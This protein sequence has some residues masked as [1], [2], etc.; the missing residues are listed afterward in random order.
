[1][2][3]ILSWKANS[4]SA[5]QDVPSILWNLEVHYYIHRSQPLVP[6]PSHMI[7]VHNLPSH[8]FKFHF[9]TIL[10]Y[11]F[12]QPCWSWCKWNILPLIQE[13]QPI[14][15]ILLTVLSWLPFMNLKATF[16]V[17]SEKI[18][19]LITRSEKRPVLIDEN[20]QSSL[21]CSSKVIYNWY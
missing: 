4:C 11:T 10:P 13:S 18:S 6:I 21:C 1:M 12:S 8:F 17:N 14:A 3:L 7:P 5:T 16:K 19:V 20:Y 2:E 9:D 15:L